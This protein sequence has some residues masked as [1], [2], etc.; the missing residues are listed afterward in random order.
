MFSRFTLL[1]CLLFSSIPSLFAAECLDVFPSAS[2]TY[3]PELTLPSFKNSSGVDGNLFGSNLAISV[4]N[5]VNIEVSQ[6]GVATFTS[7]NTEYRVEKL[8]VGQNSTVQF[9]AGDY[10]IDELRLERN[11]TLAVVGAGSVRIYADNILQFASNSRINQAGGNLIVVG[12]DDVELNGDASFTGALYVNDT[13]TLDKNVSILGAVTAEDINSNQGVITTYQESMITGSDFNGMCDNTPV[14]PAQ[15]LANYRFDECEYTGTGF[16]VID[17]TGNYSATSHGSVNTFDL[18]K[19]ERGAELVDEDHHF[20]TS[21]PLPADFSVSTWF[22]KPTSNSNSRYFVLGAMQSGGDLLYLDRN[23]SWRWGVY[24]LSTGA[25]NG[26]YSFASLDSN[27]HHMALVYSGGQTQLYID[28]TLEDTINK[29]P[30]GTLKYIGTSFDGVNSSNPQSFRSPL[31]EFIVFDGALTFAEISDIYIKQKAEN[32]YD[33]G[34]RDAVSC[35]NPSTEYRFDETQYTGAANEIIDSIGGFHGQAIVSQPTESGKVCNAIDLSA[36][37]TDNYAILD[38]AILTTKT[39]FSISLWAKT[40]KTTNQSIISGAGARNNELIMWFTSH[41]NF[42]PYLKNTHNGNITTPSIADDNWHHLVWTREGSQSCLFVDKALQGCVTQTTLPLDIQSLILGQEQDSIGGG[43]ASS[44]AFDGLL[45]EL[46]IFDS[47]ISS[48]QITTV[49]DNQDAGLGFDGSARSC[50]TPTPPVLDMRFDE[51]DWTAANSVLDSSG[52]N[53][54]ANAVDVTPT[55]G[56]ICHA[57]D[58]SASG[59]DDYI[60]LDSQALN[61]RA[62][63]TIS[64]WYKTPKTGTQSL[65]SGANA[66]SFNELIFWFTNNTLF[67]PHLKGG[68]QAI[69]TSNVSDDTWHHIVWTRS[70]S[71]NLFYHDGALQSGSASLSTDALNITSLIL[72]QEQDSLGGTFDGSQAVEGLI[73][74]LIVFKRSINATEVSSIFTNQTNGLNYDGTIRADCL[75]LLDHFEID[76]IDGQGLTC[77]A[78]NIIIK[79]CADAACSTLNTDAVDVQLSIN[80]TPHKTV[81]VVGSTDTTI[82]YTTADVATLSLDQT[83]ECVN[84]DPNA[85]DVTFADTGFRFYADSEG[86]AIPT[87][88]SGKPSNTG[89]NASTLKLQAVETNP[90]TGACEAALTD[91]VIVE[92]S[93]SCKNP[94]ACIVGNKVNINSLGTSTDISTQNDSAA[95]VYTDV[96][97]D[98][99]TNTDNAAE[100]VFTYPEA[101]QMQLHARYNIPDENGDPSG[102]YME[103]SSNGFVVRP[104]GFYVDI[105]N[106]P[107]AQSASQINSVFI[108]AGEEFTTSLTA[109][110]WKYG[111]DDNNNGVPDDDADLSGNTVTKNFGNETA[112][113]TPEKYLPIPGELGT[114]TNKVFTGFANGKVINNSMTYSE[115]GIISFTATTTDYLNVAG[116]DITGHEPYVGRFIPD[117]F[118]LTTGLDGELK[119]ICDMTSP[120]SELPFAYVGQMSSELSGK[121]ALQYELEPKLLITAKSKAD[122]NGVSST[123]QN[124]REDFMMLSESE[125]DYIIPIEDAEKI[126]ALGVKVKLTANMTDGSLSDGSL[127]GENGVVTYAFNANDNFI[128]VHEKNSETTPFPAKIELRIDSVEDAD[129]VVAIDGDSDTGNGQLWVLKPIGKEIRLGRANLENSFGP[130]TSPLGQVLSVEYFDGTNFVLASDDSCTPYNSAKVSFGSP[131]DVMLDPANIPPVSGTFIA[132]DDLPNGVTRQIVLPAVNAGNQGGVEVIYNIYDWLKYDW[133]GVD[134]LADSLLYDDNPSATATFGLFRGNDRII[135]QREVH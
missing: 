69:T 21:I 135:Y 20:E 53:Y 49:Y 88:L 35:L 31:D 51:V 16:E 6:N 77:A 131:N 124:Y 85:C 76:V 8:T 134:E 56:F 80:G 25:Q 7:S 115:V 132:L 111:D 90:I 46:L 119:S 10:W 42:R 110:Q 86:I 58:L 47:A 14:V 52:N 122:L 40:S 126:G 18:G 41:T 107:A 24:S 55:A 105:P 83:Y 112:E 121:G 100:F 60:T 89:F 128:Y 3:G 114:L 15:P 19:V 125:V 44:Q 117:H 98:F 2:Q 64:L 17:Q 63:F 11:S 96:A 116:L 81:M 87:Q 123:T 33:G 104:L 127:S 36:S 91:N 54:H 68:Y 27:W 82:N 120:S 133:N 50:P 38:E 129:H 48:A 43:F 13:L 71:E 5:Y 79:A 92:L 30:T 109:V 12:Y 65:I 29:A 84:G 93:A 37:G 39:D 70:G 73:D 101:G 74:E 94:S 75:P 113:I 67:G 118:E 9:V 99:G 72:G 97:M 108:A 28:G 32:N 106:N 102:V 26:N 22:K 59:V 45:D 95:A 23:N 4:G 103:G 78:D 61:G 57:A 66:S 130:E 62:S 1:C 34:S